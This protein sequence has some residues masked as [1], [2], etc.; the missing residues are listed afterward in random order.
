MYTS[1]HLSPS[2]TSA[3]D[4]SSESLT[5]LNLLN[6][7]TTPPLLLLNPGFCRWPPPRTEK[8]ILKKRQR[9][10]AVATWCAVVGVTRTSGWSQ[11]FTDL[12]QS[13][14]HLRS[15]FVQGIY[16]RPTKALGAELH[17][18]STSPGLHPGQKRGG[19]FESQRK[20]GRC[21]S[22]C[23]IEQHTQTKGSQLP[24]C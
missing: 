6:E 9:A 15:F 2:P 3:V 18:R 5:W 13:L 17:I 20:S 1:S 22:R 4:L 23:P 7:M 21:P 19:R 11:Q 12:G 10:R 16:S 8:E 14:S 24:P